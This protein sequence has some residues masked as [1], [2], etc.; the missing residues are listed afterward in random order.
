M[1]RRAFLLIASILVA[2]T[3]TGVVALYAKS[4]DTRAGNQ[5]DPKTVL[6]ASQDFTVG[7]TGERVG[8]ATKQQQFAQAFV[9]AD[10][11]T[12]ISQLA[13]RTAAVAIVKDRPLQ[14]S[15]FVSAGAATPG[16]AA[17]LGKGKLAVAVPLPDSA[18]VAGYV[19]DGS[20]VALFVLSGGTDKASRGDIRLLS[21]NAV[22]VLKVAPFGAAG[23]SPGQTLVTLELD[24]A[25]APKVIF[26]SQKDLLYMAL[27]ESQNTPLTSAQVFTGDYSASD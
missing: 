21:P 7:T 27:L 26:A 11:I 16:N 12:S 14:L 6:V 19:Q 9:P 23:P 4:A 10:A 18:R 1:G 2:A 5:R 24:A 8:Q 15:Q 25:L 22:K 20:Y 17:G 3:G 13:G